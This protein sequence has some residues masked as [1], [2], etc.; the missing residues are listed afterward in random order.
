MT[1]IESFQIFLF[2]PFFHIIY[3][4][5]THTHNY[6]IIY[7]EHIGPLTSLLT[8]LRL[9]SRTCSTIFFFNLAHA[10][11]QSPL[12]NGF[13]SSPFDTISCILYY[14]TFNASNF[15]LSTDYRF[16]TSILWTIVRDYFI[17]YTTLHFTEW[18]FYSSDKLW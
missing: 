17:K 15:T 9:L 7:N 1:T 12:K 5:H 14:K 2:Y 13:T 6:Y 11:P 4:P 16:F 10:W 18:I 8:Y 3:I